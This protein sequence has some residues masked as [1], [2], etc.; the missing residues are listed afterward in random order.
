MLEM[1]G[2][3]LFP[4]TSELKMTGMETFKQVTL[5][6]VKMAISGY[7]NCKGLL[8]FWEM[9]HLPV[10]VC[11][12][13]RSFLVLNHVKFIVSVKGYFFDLEDLLL[14]FI[15]GVKVRDTIHI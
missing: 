5:L 15:A 4:L 7:R 14:S 10:D 13:L 12:S 3:L 6:L 9:H 1:S 8:F 2:L 11:W